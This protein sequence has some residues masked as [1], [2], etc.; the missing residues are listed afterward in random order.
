MRLG[1]LLLRGEQ[2][3]AAARVALAWAAGVSFRLR[4]HKNM[5]RTVRGRANGFLYW[6][7]E[8]GARR[9]IGRLAG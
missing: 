4:F 9:R 1:V 7:H 5:E 2:K 8:E 6:S 3:T